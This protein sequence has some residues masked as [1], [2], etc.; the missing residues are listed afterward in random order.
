MSEERFICFL[1]E[2]I[3][4]TDPHSELSVASAKAILSNLRAM[5]SSSGKCST[6]VLRMM[7]RVQVNY[8]YFCAHRDEFA[9]L[10]GEYEKNSARRN[11]L[12]QM[13]YPGC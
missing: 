7:D 4:M 11:R 2:L 12:R 9:G 8:S 3:T 1:Q 10:P 6:L 13:L 5:A